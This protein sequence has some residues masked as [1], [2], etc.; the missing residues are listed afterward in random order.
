[1]LTTITKISLLV[2]ITYFMFVFSAHAQW[3][4][5]YFIDEHGEQTSLDY[6]GLPTEPGFVLNC[7]SAQ[8]EVSAQ[9]ISHFY[10]SEF[11][12]VFNLYD[13][14]GIADVSS[15]GPALLVAKSSTGEKFEI[16]NVQG[17]I[18]KGA[19]ARAFMDFVSAQE[20]A[21]EVELLHDSPNGRSCSYVLEISPVGS[22]E[23]LGQLEQV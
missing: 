13:A 1:M 6:A 9:V 7:T 14:Y 2:L 16:K 21:V 11:Y 5:R 23:V 19:E 8:P 10:Q 22:A 12:V 18:L 17:F 3:Q 20:D 4:H 15:D